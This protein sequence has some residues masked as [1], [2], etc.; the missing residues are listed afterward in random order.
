MQVVLLSREQ[1]IEN[2][3]A[4]HPDLVEAIICSMEPWHRDA[5][6]ALLLQDV[7]GR[8]PAN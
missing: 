1:L 7:F 4:V 5:A 3:I 8:A 2:A 6:L